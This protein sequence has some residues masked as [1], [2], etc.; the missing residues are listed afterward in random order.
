MNGETLLKS[1][2]A[3]IIKV[4]LIKKKGYKCSVVYN[5]T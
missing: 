5:Y 2:K 1:V 3:S 4:A